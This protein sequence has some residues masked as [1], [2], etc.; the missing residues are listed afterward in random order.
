MAHLY[1]SID[2]GIQKQNLI[3]FSNFFSHPIHKELGQESYVTILR[4]LTLRL[5]NGQ[6]FL[7]S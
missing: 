5:Y 2:F 3:T 1:I 6:V 4:H 7:K